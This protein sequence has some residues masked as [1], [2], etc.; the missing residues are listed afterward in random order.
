MR[1][2]YYIYYATLGLYQH[3]GPVW[4]A[5]NE[6]L[7]ETLPATQIQT[8]SRKGSWDSSRGLC[9]NGGRV[10]ST[11]LATLSLE[12][13]YRLLPMYGFRGNEAPEAK[14]KGQKNSPE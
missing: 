13:Y 12:V 14:V 2:F 4:E 8:G 10:A 7:K 11:A 5:W 1:D 9:G 3:Q 6:R